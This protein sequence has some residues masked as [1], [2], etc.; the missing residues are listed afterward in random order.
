[1]W[2]RLAALLLLL[3]PVV[4]IPD[5]PR[6]PARPSRVYDLAMLSPADA[7]SLAGSMALYR[8]EVDSLAE[9]HE[10]RIL[11]DCTS[12]DAVHRTARLL[13][14]KQVPEAVTVRAR[15]QVLRHGASWGFLELV[16]YRLLDAAEVL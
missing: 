4:A 6:H 8:I 5:A 12:P 14:V 2:H 7:A 1:M 3:V 16:E 15:L 9:E 10:G 11:V 13:P